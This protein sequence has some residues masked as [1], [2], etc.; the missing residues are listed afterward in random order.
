MLPMTPLRKRFQAASMEDTDS[1]ASDG[2]D[3]EAAGPSQP[4]A[5][6]SSP[7]SQPDGDGAWFA[8]PTRFPS[9]HARPALPPPPVPSSPASRCKARCSAGASGL[10]YCD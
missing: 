5:A 2:R 9:A 10:G 8:P 7:T 3:S 6:S 1:P 4:D